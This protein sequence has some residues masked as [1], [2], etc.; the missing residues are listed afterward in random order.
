MELLPYP[1][2]HEQAA[3][4]EFSY[5]RNA[6]LV[7][8]LNR[9]VLAN[10]RHACALYWSTPTSDWNACYHFFQVFAATFRPAGPLRLATAPDPAG[11]VRH[12]TGD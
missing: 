7:Q 11:P 10:A 4:W 9:N 2:L 6:V 5:D 3:D 12:G 1:S 8:L